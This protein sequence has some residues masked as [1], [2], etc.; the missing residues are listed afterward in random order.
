MNVEKND[1]NVSKLFEFS[2][3]FTLTGIDETEFITHV[4]LIGDEDLNRVRVHAIRESSKLR[5]NL[6]NKRWEDREA[7]LP[8]ISSYNKEKI[9]NVVNSLGL[10]DITDKAIKKIDIDLSRPKDLDSEPTLIQQ[11]EHQAKVDAWPELFNKAVTDIVTVELEKERKKLNKVTKKRLLEFYEEALIEVS[12]NQ[13]LNTRFTEEST[14]M[15]IYLDENFNV[16][17]F[18]TFEEFLNVPS[19][20]KEILLTNYRSLELSSQ[21]LK[22]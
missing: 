11:E 6:Y 15:G 18:E 14:F 8:D 17:V 10:Q 4:R 22:A 2:R 13:I 9:V 21:D 12:C 19:K 1:V 5:K 3:K 16:R 20:L 7:Y